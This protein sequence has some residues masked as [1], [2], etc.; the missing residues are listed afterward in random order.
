MPKILEDLETE[1][2]A[3]IVECLIIMKRSHLEGDLLP[4]RV[5][6]ADYV[7]QLVKHS[8]SLRAR[9]AVARRIV[10]TPRVDARMNRRYKACGSHSGWW[11]VKFLFHE[12][13]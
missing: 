2:K 8:T 7:A 3:A 10:R 13:T 11:Q 9:R 5:L 1:M 12:L 4:L 6:T